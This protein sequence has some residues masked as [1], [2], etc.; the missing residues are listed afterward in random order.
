MK[1]LQRFQKEA[2]MCILR[3]DNVLYLK[4]Y[5]CRFFFVFC[6]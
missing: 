5:W 1:G 3:D 6:F 4:S 2:S